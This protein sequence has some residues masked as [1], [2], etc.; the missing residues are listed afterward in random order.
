MMMMMMIIEK[1]QANV[2]EKLK[3]DNETLNQYG[4]LA[5]QFHMGGGVLPTAPKPAAA[6]APTTTATPTAVADASTTASS[7]PSVASN[8]AP[9]DAATLLPID[10]GNPIIACETFG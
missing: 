9:H 10:L 7:T 8:E 4:F 6:A 2:R 1:E 3:L 5:K